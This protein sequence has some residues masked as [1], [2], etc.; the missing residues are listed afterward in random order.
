MQTKSGQLFIWK[1]KKKSKPNLCFVSKKSKK[2]KGKARKAKL[3]LVYFLIITQYFSHTD[4]TTLSIK[5]I[6]NKML[7]TEEAFESLL[8]TY[9]MK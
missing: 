4:A 2:S 9:P 7:V 1:G 8:K 5:K 6:L 3:R